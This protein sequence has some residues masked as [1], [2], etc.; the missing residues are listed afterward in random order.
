V[1]GRELVSAQGLKIVAYTFP[2]TQPRAVLTA[3]VR[4]YVE[5]SEV[6][7]APNKARHVCE[8]RRAG[9]AGVSRENAA[10]GRFQQSAKQRDE[11]A[12]ILP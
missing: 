2:P 11:R 4:W 10:G 5:P 3:L 12:V 8:R 1:D 7:A 6:H 9:E